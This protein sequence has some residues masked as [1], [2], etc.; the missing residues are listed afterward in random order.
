MRNTPD[1]VTI[2]LQMGLNRRMYAGG[3]ISYAMYSH[4]N[5][6]LISRLTKAET[7]GII[8]LNEVIAGNQI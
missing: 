2:K 4:A 3:K 7:C 1:P 8:T 6:V 5:E